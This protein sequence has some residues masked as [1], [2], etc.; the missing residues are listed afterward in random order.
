MLLEG[1]AYFAKCG[2]EEAH[3]ACFE[4]VLSRQIGDFKVRFGGIYTERRTK[5]GGWNARNPAAI[6]R[7][8]IENVPEVGAGKHVFL[9]AAVVDRQGNAATWCPDD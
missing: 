8:V 4:E 2:L 1:R 7:R 6:A 3:W 9:S 5:K